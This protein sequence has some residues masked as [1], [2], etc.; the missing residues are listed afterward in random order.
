M[1]KAVSGN[2]FIKRDEKATE[3][4]GMCVSEGAQVKNHEGVVVSIDADFGVNAGDRVQIPHY[5]V[6]DMVVDGVEYAVAKASGLSAKIE[7]GK[8]SPVNRFVML[9]KCVNDHVRDESGEIALFM[10]EK[11]IEFTHWMEIIDV[12]NDCRKVGREY[13]GYFC[14][15]PEDSDK[16]C[17]IGHTKDYCLHEDAIEFVTDGG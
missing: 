9:R 2:V 4:L 5:G 14:V 11:H 3:H 12:S 17:R 15:A 7:N 13:V 6:N 8:Y 1:I 16:L 10:T